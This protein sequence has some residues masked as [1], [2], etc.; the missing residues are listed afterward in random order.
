MIII[1]EDIG[2]G[3][4]MDT[5][6]I[7]ETMIMEFE[8]IEMTNLD[9]ILPKMSSHHTRASSVKTGDVI[10]SVI[11]NSDGS[12]FAKI[13]L[14]SGLPRS[15]VLNTK[16]LFLDRLH[17]LYLKY[18]RSGAIHE[19]NVSHYQRN[20]ITESIRKNVEN[21]KI[22]KVVTISNDDDNDIDNNNEIDITGY[23]L[24]NIMDGACIEILMLM[25]DSYKRFI[26]SRKTDFS[27]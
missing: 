10:S 16:Q 3:I 11:H 17:E 22:Q 24:F 23:S 2:I 26:L 18:I 12:V 9:E 25:L 7:P 6:I 14:P 8:S 21:D 4:D 15:E 27:E 20:R 1:E 19:I 5:M 13:K